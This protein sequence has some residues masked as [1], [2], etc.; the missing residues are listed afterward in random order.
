MK[1][2]K[3]KPDFV[4]GF[5]DRHLKRGIVKT[6]TTFAA[7]CDA[8]I[9]SKKCTAENQEAEFMQILSTAEELRNEFVADEEDIRRIVE[10][11]WDVITPDMAAELLSDILSHVKD[12]L[13]DF[14][15]FTRIDLILFA[16]RQAFLCGF[17]RALYLTSLSTMTAIEKLTEKAAHED[18]TPENG[19]N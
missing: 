11:Q 9:N 3:P 2:R 1:L 13:P 18:V 8:V 7:E 5:S 6:C 12:A 15:E 17:E 16:M 10:S 19:N 14:E 4:P